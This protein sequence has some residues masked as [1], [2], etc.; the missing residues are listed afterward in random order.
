MADV[1]GKPA[2]EEMKQMAEIMAILGS[3]G[4]VGAGIATCC[5]VWHRRVETS[6]RKV[7]VVVVPSTHGRQAT[8]FSATNSYVRL[9]RD[10]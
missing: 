6:L 4:L 9:I 10:P 7:P 2:D 3:I 1:E 5:S 8:D